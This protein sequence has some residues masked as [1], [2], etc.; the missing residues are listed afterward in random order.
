[1]TV[2]PNSKKEDEENIEELEDAAIRD[3]YEESDIIKESDNED[4]NTDDELSTDD[5]DD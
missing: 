1:M 3:I 4:I 2:P 5:C